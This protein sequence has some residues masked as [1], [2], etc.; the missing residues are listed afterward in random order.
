MKNL[1]EIA[2]LFFKL[3]VIGFGGPAA[4]IAM[5]QE[6]VVDKRGWMSRE[7]FLDLVGATNLI[8][9]PNSTE[10]AIHTGYHRGGLPG[11]VIAGLCFILPAVLSTGLLAW[12]YVT[13]GTLPALEPFFYGI[14]PAVIAVILSAVW[15]LGQKAVKG[16]LLI[17]LGILVMVV[18][19]GTGLNEVLLILGGGLLGMVVKQL[20]QGGGDLKKQWGWW[21]LPGVLSGAG[22][23]VAAISLNGIFLTFLKIGAVL[24]GSG[25]VLIAFLEGELVHNL[26]WLS[27]TQLLDAVAIGQFTPGP[28]LSTA[29][30]IGY[31]IAGWPGAT[32]ATLGIF[33][34]S[35]V[36]VL[37]L[38]PLVPR[39]R[40]SPWTAAFLDAVNVSALGLMA[41]VT[42][43][44]GFGVLGDWRAAL[45]A[46]LAAG[47]VFSGKKI[48]PAWIIVG[49]A[50]L[51]YLLTLL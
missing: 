34:P 22:K 10:M 2:A 51:G 3:G 42:V 41:A 15:K 17:G 49:G 47:V 32:L 18:N 44:L 23:G 24:F 35:F 4:H 46:L 25:Y 48:N 39:L 16:P 6:E 37:L 20:L 7:H 28:V 50:L 40:K 26:G 13:W 5:M 27:E 45:I 30:F 9:G 8:P 38:N 33:L 1:K 21:I 11:L 29:T 19:L 43:K 31:L 14:K 12:V 36:F